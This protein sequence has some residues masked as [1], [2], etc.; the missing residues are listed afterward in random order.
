MQKENMNGMDKPQVGK[1]S[2]SDLAV[3][4]Y[5]RTIGVE[6]EVEKK[7]YKGIFHYPIEHQTDVDKFFKNEGKHLSFS[8]NMRSLKSEIQ[9]KKGG[10]K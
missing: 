8:M 10:E 1:Y 5:L 9:N 3:A 2:T 7:H 4:S 6:V